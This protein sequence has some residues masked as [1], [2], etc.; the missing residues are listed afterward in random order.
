[1]TTFQINLIIFY[2][3]VTPESKFI[4]FRISIVMKNSYILQTSMNNMFSNLPLE[5]IISQVC[6]ATLNC[7]HEHLAAIYAHFA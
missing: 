3:K 4:E 7:T 6:Y 5:R 1:M 2:L